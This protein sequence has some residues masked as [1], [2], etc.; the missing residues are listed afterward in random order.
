M[1]LV[2]HYFSDSKTNLKSDCYSMAEI[3]IEHLEYLPFENSLLRGEDISWQITDGV[4][5]IFV[6]YR[7]TTKRVEEITELCGDLTVVTDTNRPETKA[8]LG[9]GVLGKL[10]LGKY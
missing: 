2:V 5:Q 10:Q 4:L 8:I 9:V 3:V 7:F 1:P 6:T